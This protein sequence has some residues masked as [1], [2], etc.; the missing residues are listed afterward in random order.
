MPP[1]GDDPIAGRVALF[2]HFPVLVGRLPWVVLGHYPTPIEPLALAE[3]PGAALWLKRE[4]RSGARPL[5]AL[6]APAVVAAHASAD[7][8]AAGWPGYGGNKVRTIEGHVGRA[9]ALGRKR[10]WATGAYGS[11]HALATALHAPRAGLKVGAILAPQPPSLPA[12]ANLRA[13][14]ASGAEITTVSAWLTRPWRAAALLADGDEVVMTPG[15]AVAVGALGHVSAALELAAQ[16]RAGALPAP[17]HIVVT[18]GSTATTAGLLVGLAI[19]ADLGLGWS[20]PPTLHAV[21]VAPWPVTSATAIIWLA[22]RTLAALLVLLEGGPGRAPDVDPARLAAGLRVD[23]SHY[24]AGYGTPHAAGRRAQLAYAAAGAPPLDTVYTARSGAAT[25]ALCG[26]AE[27]P[28]V[29]W[30]SKSSLPLA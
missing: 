14:A 3:A 8:H 26:R 13:L 15:G 17:R 18:T 27:G 2:E 23:G 29:H 12:Q 10:I 4:D 7:G 6:A 11:N 28:I 22:R 9:V 24:G 25:L 21:R 20:A 19:A 1:A 30:M 16:V 5:D